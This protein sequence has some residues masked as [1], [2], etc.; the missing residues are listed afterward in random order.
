MSQNTAFTPVT[1]VTEQPCPPF[2][3]LLSSALAVV[4]VLCDLL[5]VSTVRASHNTRMA[6]D[7]GRQGTGMTGAGERALPANKG[8]DFR[9]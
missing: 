7:G 2:P 4:T 8:C 5:G 3:A 1:T 9:A 6:P